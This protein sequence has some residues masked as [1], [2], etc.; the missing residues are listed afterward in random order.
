MEEQVDSLQGEAGSHSINAGRTHNPASAGSTQAPATTSAGF[1][2]CPESMAALISIRR[3]SKRYKLTHVFDPVDE[4]DWREYSKMTRMLLETTGDDDNPQLKTD[5][6]TAE[7][8]EWLWLRRIRS[9]EGYGELPSD[10]KDK[11]PFAHRKAALQALSTVAALYD[12]DLLE[13][14]VEDAEPGVFALDGGE[15]EVVI[16]ATRN[17]EGYPLL[18]HF[19]RPPPTSQQ[20]EWSR[21]KGAGVIVRGR[22]G[23]G[24]K[25]IVSSN[26]GY[27][28]GLYDGLI[29]KVEGYEPNDPQQMDAVHK[30]VAVEALLGNG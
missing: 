23:K 21:R 16:E 15:V 22:R 19:F 10:W 4:G 28:L 25:Q 18:K 1:P 11:I 27:L 29:V 9:V 8:I 3:G 20:K 26:L 14:G 2:L 7:A 24:T 17:G 5:A 12:E 6:E 13:E 30:R